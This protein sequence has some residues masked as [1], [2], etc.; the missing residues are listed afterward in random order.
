M[1]ANPKLIR[2]INQLNNLKT[3]VTYVSLEA[4]EM[5][6]AVDIIFNVLSA[7]TNVETAKFI[8]E[9]EAQ[10]HSALIIALWPSGVFMGG[11]KL[12]LIY[13]VGDLKI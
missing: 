13:K 2:S 6:S 3:I 7:N 11:S 12:Y 10:C 4:D 9:N 5:K 1:L 8:L